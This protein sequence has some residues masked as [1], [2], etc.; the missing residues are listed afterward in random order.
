[1]KRKPDK[2]DAIVSQAYNQESSKEGERK[3][4]QI[5]NGYG[6]H[7][8]HTSENTQLHL[9]V[10]CTLYKSDMIKNLNGGM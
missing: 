8:G 2:A 10:V 3:N 7:Q 1:M 9:Q 4:R 6:L 5:M